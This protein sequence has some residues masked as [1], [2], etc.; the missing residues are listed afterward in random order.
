MANIAEWEK[1]IEELSESEKKKI[2]E[3]LRTLMGWDFFRK[4]FDGFGLATI[5]QIAEGVDRHAKDKK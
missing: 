5:Q 3:S 4:A 2:I 1:E